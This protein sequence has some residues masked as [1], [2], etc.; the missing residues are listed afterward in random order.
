MSVPTFKQLKEDAETYQKH[1]GY[2]HVRIEKLRVM[3]TR[4]LNRWSSEDD[5]HSDSSFNAG[6]RREARKLVEGT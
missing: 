5:G 4:V 2:A 1:L 3:L 6:L